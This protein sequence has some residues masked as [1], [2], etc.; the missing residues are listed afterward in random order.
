[1]VNVLQRVVE[2]CGKYARRTEAA[3]AAAAANKQTNKQT[4]IQQ[5]GSRWG[6]EG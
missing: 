3:A 2:N 4:N 6:G 1:M 5:R